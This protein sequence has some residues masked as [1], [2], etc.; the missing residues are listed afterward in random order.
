MDPLTIALV[1]GAA[2]L[3]L[4]RKGSVQVDPAAVAANMVIPP[5][6]PFTPFPPVKVSAAYAAEAVPVAL[7]DATALGSELAG[8]VRGV[9][10]GAVTRPAPVPSP[11]SRPREQI[12]LAHIERGDIR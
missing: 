4:R 1:A 12:L 3:L 9:A 5:P 8:F 10:V 2:L 7:S 11:V 6:E